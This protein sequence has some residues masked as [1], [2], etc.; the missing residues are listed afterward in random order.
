MS[1]FSDNQL[2]I[3]QSTNKRVLL[4]VQL[5]AIAVF[6]GRAYQHIFWD[7][8]FRTILWDETWM[9]P[10]ISG[11]WSEWVTNPNVDAAIQNSITYTGYF[12]LFC[13]LI[14]I[15]ARWI[16]AVFRKI[17][18]LGAGVLMLLAFLYLKEKFWAI[19][20]FF[21][22]SLQFTAPIFLYYLLK[23]RVCTERMIL[24]LKLA[25][26]ITFVCHGLYAV[27]YYA[28]PGHFVQMFINV[29]GISESNAVNLLNLA[30]FADFALAIMLFIPKRK[31]QIAAAAYAIFWGFMTS[32]AR[33]WANFYP[34]FWEQ[35][36]HQFGFEMLMRLPHFLMPMALLM[37]L[38]KLNSNIKMH[39]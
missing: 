25:V 27:G 19:G 5:S 11:P 20:Q 6:L 36:L 2:N 21:E 24:Y 1:Y 13:A 7:A 18:L 34:D 3:P 10:F 33:V 37:L 35:S 30:G 12:Y 39:K 4:L 14:A 28:R 38:L 8:P 15:I 9:S 23:Q 29:L 31:I 22:Y 17:L 26:A 32:I 16:P